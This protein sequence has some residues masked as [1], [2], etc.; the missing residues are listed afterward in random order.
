[1]PSRDESS[2]IGGGKRVPEVYGIFS[3]GAGRT[4]DAWCFDCDMAAAV[5]AANSLSWAWCALDRDHIGMA[6]DTAA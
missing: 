4:S 1:M 5:R 2:D 3:S 6:P